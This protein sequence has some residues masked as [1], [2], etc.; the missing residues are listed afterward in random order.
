MSTLD[1]SG[2]GLE[3]PSDELMD[4]LVRSG[5]PE[6]CKRII[7][8]G[9][10]VAD[11]FD[12]DGCIRP[13]Y[14]Y[15]GRGPSQSTL[16]IGHL[17][18][19]QLTRAMQ[20][21]SDRR[22]FF[23]LSDDEKS[24]RDG[25]PMEEVTANAHATIQQLDDL[26]FSPA[27]MH[28][29]LN[30]TG[31]SSDFYSM[32]IRISSTLTPNQVLHS[33]GE[34]G[35]I[36][37]MFYPVV[38]MAP[39]F[40]HALPSE[41]DNSLLCVVVAGEDQDPFFRLARVAARKLGLPQPIILYT[42]NVP[43]LDGSAKMSTSVPTSRPIFLTDKA[44]AVHKAVDSIAI[45]GAGTTK[46]LFERGANLNRDISFRIFAMFCDD[47]ELVNVVS[48]AYTCGIDMSAADFDAKVNKINTTVACVPTAKPVPHKLQN[49]GRQFIGSRTMRDILE[50]TLLHMLKLC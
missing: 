46:E 10:G 21:I 36:G 44:A 41:F 42:H 35:S 4:A 17:P 3:C 32:V 23:M 14:V 16:H 50:A 34:K 6:R 13:F 20:Q 29:H 1:E 27:N 25:T 31:M 45:M 40:P 38:Q 28:V 24:L 48:E 19:L 43:G 37:E 49:E 18:G 30:S 5:L 15:T 12:T 9:R 2:F 8:S 11:L 26:G 47:I 39:C 33:F 7:R 22:M